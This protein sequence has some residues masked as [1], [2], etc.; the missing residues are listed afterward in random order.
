ML[1]CNLFCDQSCIFSI[2]TPV[3]SVTWSS[4]III[5]CWFAAQ[6]TFLIIISVENSCAAE[7]VEIVIYF[8]FRILKVQK[9]IVLNY[10]LEFIYCPVW[11]S[12]CILAESIKRK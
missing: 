4:E 3:F 5:I 6:E 9:E 10:H 2:I 11:S 7:Y 8:I 1:K 12:S